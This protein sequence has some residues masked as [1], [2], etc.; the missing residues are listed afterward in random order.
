MPPIPTVDT[1]EVQRLLEQGAQLVDVLPRNTFL[2]EHLPGAVNLPIADIGN[3]REEL[4]PTRPVIVYC[5][6]YQCDLSARAATLLRTLGFDEVYDY[7]TSKV[8]WLAEGLPGAG[9]LQDRARVG[10][11]VRADVPVV[12]V[13]DDVAALRK[14]IDDWE[15]AVV[16]DDDRTMLGVVRAEAVAMPDDIPLASIMAPEAPSVRPSIPLRELAESMDRNGEQHILV[17]TL[18]GELLG[19]VRREDL[20][21]G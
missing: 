9:R 18:R 20:D 21:R 17:T 16:V 14:V 3:A 2:E 11:H 8:A 5:Y 4:D 6:D 1:D 13:A 10:P 7:A 19:L 12:D 15:L